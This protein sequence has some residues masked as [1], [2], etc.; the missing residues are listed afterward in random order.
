MRWGLA[1]GCLAFAVA[2]APRAAHAQDDE[3]ETGRVAGSVILGI[4]AGGLGGAL[5]GFA[6]S[7]LSEQ[8]DDC[9]SDLVPVVIG[10]QIGMNLGLAGGVTIGGNHEGGK[11]SFAVSLGAGVAFSGLGWLLINQGDGSAPFPGGFVAVG[12]LLPIPATMIGYWGTHEHAE[13]KIVPT[14]NGVAV[15]GRF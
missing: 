2:V 4:L 13:L 5:G 7:K 6:G 11:G 10:A 3:S 9:D 15:V 1:A 14:S 8:C 12:V